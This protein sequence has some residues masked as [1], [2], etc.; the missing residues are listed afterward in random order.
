MLNNL[1]VLQNG[2]K[3]LKYLQQTVHTDFPFLF[4]KIKAVDFDKEVAKLH[5]EIPSLEA[6]ELPVAMA[7]I[8]SLF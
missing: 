2:K 8:V 5:A 3:D 1:L 7:R 6:H 4:K